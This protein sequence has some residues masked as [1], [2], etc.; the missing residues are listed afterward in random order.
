MVKQ[1]ESKNAENKV[2]VY[3]KVR[4][5]RRVLV[6]AGQALC[7]SAY[8][9][10]LRA[11]AA[12]CFVTG[13]DLLKII[14]EARYGPQPARCQLLGEYSLAWQ[15]H[16]RRRLRF[17]IYHVCVQTYCP[18]CSRAKSLF[19]EL[20]VDAKVI[21]LDNMGAPFPVSTSVAW[22][23]CMHGRVPPWGRGPPYLSWQAPCQPFGCKLLAGP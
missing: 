8:A 13:C 11:R 15:T 21:E 7:T 4:A 20:G 12:L 3:S 1:I 14:R 18:Y 9:L 23:S 5:F 6:R 17:N 10:I 19:Q 22:R 16:H 2:I